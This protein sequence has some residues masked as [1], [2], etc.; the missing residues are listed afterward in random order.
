ML[1]NER[2]TCL[3]VRSSPQGVAY[4]STLPMV[5]DNRAGVDGAS[6]P[7]E[8]LEA[9]RTRNAQKWRRSG[10]GAVR[11]D[12]R[13][14]QRTSAGDPTHL[15]KRSEGVHVADLSPRRHGDAALRGFVRRFWVAQDSLAEKNSTP[16][17]SLERFQT[18]SR[19]SIRARRSR[20]LRR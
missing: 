8:K 13:P 4:I 3:R 12:R 14:P 18:P 10:E 20:G 16:N 2:P 15:P 19:L 6:A 9:T 11:C 17:F 1:Q 7:Q 5:V